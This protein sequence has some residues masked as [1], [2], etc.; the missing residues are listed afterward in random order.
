MGMGNLSSAR[1]G[2]LV[3]GRWRRR[4]AN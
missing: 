4:E 1:Q 2:R 3:Q